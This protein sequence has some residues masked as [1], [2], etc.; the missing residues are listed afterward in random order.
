MK[1][2]QVLII[3]GIAF[4]G[5]ILSVTLYFLHEVNQKEEIVFEECSGELM[6]QA[7]VT[8][9]VE[10]GSKIPFMHYVTTSG[11]VLCSNYIKVNPKKEGIV[12]NI[13]IKEGD[14][15][16]IGDE[17]LQI[18][19][20]ML[21]YTYQEKAIDYEVAL[22]EL[23]LCEHENEFLK[24]VIRK[25]EIVMHAAEKALQDCKIT[26]FAEGRV[27]KV[28][29]HPGEYISPN[30]E[31][32]LIGVDNPLHLKVLLDENDVWKINPTKN[33]RALA[34]HRTN[35][36]IHFVLDF[37]ALNHSIDP[38]NKLEMI[39]SFDKGKAPLYLDQTLDVYIESISPQDASYL[40]YEFKQK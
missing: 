4:Q 22:A 30:E 35:P 19:P 29:V 11:K 34:F 25:K 37:V 23:K 1:L 27:L 15:V 9:V 6:S 10:K 3:S 26:S 14:I 16:K 40:D 39:F 28:N 12:Q 8:Q 18:D 24:S 17:L 36:T 5:V 7:E 2:K 31:A 13:F 32:I 20:E 33:M 21:T 38:S